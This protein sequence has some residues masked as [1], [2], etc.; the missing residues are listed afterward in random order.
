MKFDKLVNL[1]L[2]GIDSG[3][4]NGIAFRKANNG[5]DIG[6]CIGV[7]HGSTPTLSEDLIKRIKAMNGGK[8]SG[9]FAEG[10]DKDP[11]NPILTQIKI[12][13]AGNWDKVLEDKNKGARNPKYN[14]VYIFMQSDV[15]SNPNYVGKFKGKTIREAITN[16][17]KTNTG[18]IPV[19]AIDDIAKAGFGEYLDKPFSIELL[20][21]LF[22]KLNNTVYVPP[23]YELNPKSFFGAKMEKIE[24]ER[25]QSLFNCMANGGV[26][27][28][29]AGHLTELKKQFPND[30]EL[31]DAEKTII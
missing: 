8:L 31:L 11:I 26:A 12:K 30:I 6:C 16:W 18:N 4:S 5:T 2:E 3:S 25:N 23:N 19:D 14:S 1:I 27:F 28:A 22:E 13:R 9:A 7:K 17:L 10:A 24:E 20:K 15:E 21:D 29:G